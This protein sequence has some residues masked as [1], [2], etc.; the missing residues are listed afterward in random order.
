MARIAYEKD[1]N[2]AQR[3][4]VL[5]DEGP[6]LVIAGAGSGKTRVLT[7]KLAHL[8][9]EG[10]PAHKLMALTFTN[11]AADEM[12]QRVEEL[13]G[14]GT[15]REMMV[16]TF[17]AI[18]SR[19]LR[20]YA[21]LLGFNR[22]F[23][24]FDTSDSR[25][26]IKQVIA[27]L[28]LDSKIYSPATLQYIISDAKNRLTSPQSYASDPELRRYDTFKGMPEVYRIYEAYA[29]ALKQA[30]AM[31]F[32]DL[33]YLFNVLLR[34]FPAVSQECQSMIDYLLIDEYQDTNATQYYIARQLVM[35]KQKIFAVGDDAQSIYSFRG[36]DI[37]NILEF[38][39]NFS[40]ARLFKLEQNYRSTKT[41]VNLAND[42]I[43]KN[44]QGI[45][46]KLYSPH[47]AP[48]S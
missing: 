19:F 22:Q 37:N 39:R 9:E 7:Y 25:A 13:V 3:E 23:T 45:P 34:D 12:K 41:I 20:R 47:V 4:A 21:A 8:I 10:Y 33:L 28:E 27:Q 43:A 17:H 5:Y 16:G 38:T 24:I 1:L 44:Q 48:S 30:N 2:A 42:L 31:D 32:D 35:N 29:L 6:A 40:G 46:K 18:F 11:K 26:L 36:A 15:A 14:S